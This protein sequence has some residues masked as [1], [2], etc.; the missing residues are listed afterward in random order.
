[1]KEKLSVRNIAAVS[2]IEIMMN[3][4]IIGVVT[5]ASMGLSKPKADYMRNIK[6]YSALVT[7]ERAGR[8]IAQ[9]GHID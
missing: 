8:A 9:E 3:L 5:A 2:L 7:L 6:L 1:M 4:T